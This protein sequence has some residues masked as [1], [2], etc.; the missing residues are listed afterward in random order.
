MHVSGWRNSPTHLLHPQRNVS[1][2]LNMTEHS[3]SSERLLIIHSE[4]KLLMLLMKKK[5]GEKM[6]RNTK[7]G[8]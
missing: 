6:Q 7:T 8:G 1:V 5:A 3:S 4:I 2:I